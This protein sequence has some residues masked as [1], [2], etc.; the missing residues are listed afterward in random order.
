MVWVAVGDGRIAICNTN[1]PDQEI[2]YMET[3]RFPDNA[4][5]LINICSIGE[6]TVVLGYASGTLLFVEHPEMGHDCFLLLSVVLELEKPQVTE[7]VQCQSGLHDVEFISSIQEL[8]CGC[9]NGVIEIFD[10]SKRVVASKNT[11]NL[12]SQSPDALQNSAVLQL[13]LASLN[14][15]ALHRSNVISC[16]R[17][18][19][20]CLI[21]VISPNF[22]G[23]KIFYI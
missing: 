12:Q 13:K 10:L 21:K 6:H 15:F 17:V 23:L 18:N 1:C 19:D 16:W 5:N 7:S 11:L 14:V 20:H 2:C 4:V 9:E 3:N 8:W 22:Q